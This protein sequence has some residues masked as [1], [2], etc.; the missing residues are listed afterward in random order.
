MI[1]SKCLK[2]NSNI[3]PASIKHLCLYLK[4]VYTNF[5]GNVNAS[6]Q[7]MVFTPEIT[8]NIVLPWIERVCSCQGEEIN[9]SC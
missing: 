5:L 9:S 6:G 2:M 7:L 1:A 8:C 3:P 4:C